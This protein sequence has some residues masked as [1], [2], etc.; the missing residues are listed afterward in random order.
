[1]KSSKNSNC[2]SAVLFYFFFSS[3]YWSQYRE[4]RYTDS[5]DPDSESEWLLPSSH[6]SGNVKSFMALCAA[7]GKRLPNCS[8]FFTDSVHSGK[9]SLQLGHQSLFRFHLPH[10]THSVL[11]PGGRESTYFLL[12]MGWAFWQCAL[13]TD[14]YQRVCCVLV[15]SNLTP[16]SL[17]IH[18]S[19]S[20]GMGRRENLS[21]SPGP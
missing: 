10:L 6:F 8:C 21:N 9:A 4:K 1:M 20:E 12:S 7:F 13:S 3:M 18:V 16:C 11:D 19:E 2:P 14:L 5:S 17:C 15:F